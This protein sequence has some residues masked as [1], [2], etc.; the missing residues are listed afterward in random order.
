MTCRLERRF[1]SL[2]LHQGPEADVRAESTGARA[3]EAPDRGAGR[4]KRQAA[5]AGRCPPERDPA[6]RNR[7]AT[8]ADA[9]LAGR[10]AEGSR[11]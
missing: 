7:T 5:K 2:D 11:G 3:K 9:R 4:C 8:A 6:A 10:P 1:L